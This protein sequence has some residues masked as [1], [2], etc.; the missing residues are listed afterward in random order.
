[1]VTLTATPGS[2]SSFSGWSGDCSGTGDCVLTMDAGRNVTANFSILPPIA[3]FSASVVTGSAPLIVV[4]SDT[5][6]NAPAAWLWDFGDGNTSTQQNPTHVYDQ[7]GT[8]TVSLTA[9]N[10]SGSGVMIKT[11]YISAGICANLPVKADD[12]YYAN[13][14]AAYNDS[15]LDG[16][17][18]EVQAGSLTEDLVFDQNVSFTL[19]G[20]KNCEYTAAASASTVHGVMTV[21]DGTVVVENLV[22]Q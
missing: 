9:T 11:D 15:R 20:G 17:I 5:S 19:V 13:I 6:I 8:Y 18:I 1:M 7:D 10:T 12:V 3:D 14:Q 21:S 22:I 2:S 4:F 16:D